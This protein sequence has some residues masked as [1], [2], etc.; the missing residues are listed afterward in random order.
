MQEDEMGNTLAA[1]SND[2]ASAVERAGHSIV[3]VHARHRFS[4]GGVVWGPGVIVTADHTIKRDEEIKVTLPGGQTAPA[5]LA[6]RDPGTDLALLSV[7]G[8]TPPM[9]EFAP[10]ESLQPGNI[11]LAV[12]RSTEGGLSATM[13]V[14]STVSGPTRTWRGGSLDQLIRL[15]I[16][17]FPGSSGGAVVDTQGRVIGIASSALSRIAGI[18]IPVKTVDRT[19]DE[20]A[21]KGYIAR[22]Y[23]GVALQRVSLPEHLR[24]TLRS[25]AASGLMIL[26]VEPGGPAEKA[27]VLLGD[28]LISLDGKPLGEAD[29]LQEALR[30]ES[31]GRAVNALVLRGGSPAELQIK[32]GERR[33]S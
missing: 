15:D 19:A 13:G 16:T 22:G 7:D 33:R 29:D 10:T 26:T 8:E 24:G 12:A 9:P 14:V 6:G 20:L 18:A 28:I 5:K 2:L 23:L 25:P 21:R 17:L 27:G 1:L 11:V 4:S 31:V 3:A 30:P 32:V